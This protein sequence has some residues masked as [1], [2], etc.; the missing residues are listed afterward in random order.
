MSRQN[1]KMLSPRCTY[2]RTA[3]FKCHCKLF[4][5]VFSTHCSRYKAEPQFSQMPNSDS[6]L[7][8]SET[9]GDNDEVNENE[10]LARGQAVLLTTGFRPDKEMFVVLQRSKISVYKDEA[11]FTVSHYLSLKHQLRF[12]EL[13]L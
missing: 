2:H 4:K 6:N 8:G 9:S 11:H 5:H 3:H 7:G 1:C 12:L 10:E 13:I